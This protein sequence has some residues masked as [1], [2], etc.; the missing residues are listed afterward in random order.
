MTTSVASST[1]LTTN[2]WLRTLTR[3]THPRLRL[4]CIPPAGAGPH[5]YRMWATGLPQDVE[6]LA[7]HLPGR[8]SRFTE[9][10]MTDYHRAVEAVYAG[11]RPALDPLPYAI[12]GHSMGAL[13]A[14]GLALTAA[15]MGSPAPEHLLLSGVGGPR[16][17][18]PKTGRGHWGDTEL[19]ADLRAMG[20]TTAEILENP[21]LLDIL[22]PIL[23]ADYTLCESFRAAPPTGPPLS[24]PVTVLGGADDDCTPADLACWADVCSGP[25][26]QHTFSGGHFFLTRESAQPV[27]ATVTSAVS[28]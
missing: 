27:L 18:P 15:R 23:R 13:L 22:L 14:Y 7:V 5:F 10:P 11:V 16:G 19:V 25:F 21:E 17:T 4:I 6:V 9:P 28:R 1:D 3:G 2:P 26:A 8:E 12:F 24:V 20:G